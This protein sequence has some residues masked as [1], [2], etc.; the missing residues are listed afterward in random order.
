MSNVY[1]QAVVSPYVVVTHDQYMALWALG[2]DVEEDDGKLT[3]EVRQL[4]DRWRAMIEYMADGSDEV[5]AWST[6]HVDIDRAFSSV[7]PRTETSD[8]TVSRVREA[9]RAA[10]TYNLWIYFE[11]GYQDG[12]ERVLQDI[13]RG[14][15]ARATRRSTRSPE[16]TRRT[17][18][19]TSTAAS[20]TSSPPTTSS[21]S[22]RSSGYTRRRGSTSP[23]D[24]F[25]LRL[26]PARHRARGRQR[27]WLPVE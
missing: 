7:G 25:W 5:G 2:R 15:N 14:T 11:D 19:E 23:P 9:C 1:Q 3:E 22:A 16:P 13:L 26:T 18:S 4:A 20:P 17:G 12:F 8:T 10:D 21:R 27:D 24:P 6:H